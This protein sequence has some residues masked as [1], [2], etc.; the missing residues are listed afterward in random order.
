MRIKFAVLILSLAAYALFGVQPTMAQNART[1]Y[2]GTNWG[3]VPIPTIQPKWSI[4][5]DMPE[6]DLQM[7]LGTIAT[8][9]GQAYVLQKGRLLAV[10]TKTGKKSW[11]FGAKLS[12]PV[13]Y[14]KGEVYVSSQDGTLYAVNAANG[15]KKWGTTVKTSGINQL[16]VNGDRLFAVNGHVQAFDLKSGKWLW[17]DDYPELFVG[18]PLW[19]TSGK[20]LIS[21]VISGAYSYDALLAFDENSGHLVWTAGNASMPLLMKSN[22]VVVQRTSNWLTQVELTT[23]DTLD[24]LTGKVVKTVEY[25]QNGSAWI[26][27]ER[28]YISVSGA[29]YGYPLDADPAKTIRDSYKPEGGIQNHWAGGPDAGR[30]LFTDGMQFTGVKLVNKSTVLYGWMGNPIARFDA[31]GNGVYIALT[32]GKVVVVNL[33]TAKRLFEL[34]MPSRVFGPT[35]QDDGMIIVQSKGRVSAFPEPEQLKTT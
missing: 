27:S 23:L 6:D 30:L 2:I 18:G 17:T 28:V 3:P 5:T 25:P 14:S 11:A 15:K 9:D 1:S 4:S 10:N 7:S 29:V 12:S 32:D 22:T 26:D 35:L 34:Q 31:I 24:V 20:I 8:G 21:T 33:I 13:F 19:F 16:Y